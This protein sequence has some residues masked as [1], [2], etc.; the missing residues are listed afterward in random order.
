[1]IRCKPGTETLVEDFL[2]RRF[3]NTIESIVRMEKEDLELPNHLSGKKGRFLKLVFRNTIDLS[4]VRRVLQPAV[5]KNAEI[6]KE[7]GLHAED[8]SV[9]E[10]SLPHSRKNPDAYGLNNIV[11]IREH[12]LPYHLRVNIDLGICCGLWYTVGAQAGKIRCDRIAEKNVRPDPVVFAFDIET[13]KL[14][15]KFPDAANDPIM[16]ISYMIDGKVATMI[17]PFLCNRFDLPLLLG[18]LGYQQKHCQ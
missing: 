8:F 10:S 16:M 14:P 7:R 4:A 2:R 17:M 18:L 9:C 11:D 15:L 12:D 1:M 3:E 5:A 13:S 6:A